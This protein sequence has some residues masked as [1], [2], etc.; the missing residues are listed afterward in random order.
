[1]ATH[2]RTFLKA[3]TISTG[4]AAALVGSI[5]SFIPKARA[6][7][8]V[9]T[10]YDKLPV[11][12]GNLERYPPF[13]KWNG[14]REMDGDDWKRGGIL[15]HDVKVNDYM[16]VP[17]VCNNC[18]A[19]CGLTA[20][21][22][23]E[24]LTVRKYMGN[25]LHTGS[26]GRNCAKG[27]AV[28]TQMYDPDRI[29]FPLKRAPGTKRGDGKW[30]RTTWDEAMATIGGK[31]REA[32][33]KGDEFTK[34]SIM[35]HVGRPNESGFTPRVW[36][37]LGQDF[38]N[39][40]T[41]ICSASGRF[42]SLLW[43]NDDR[44]SSD[45]SNARLI[46]LISS[47]AADAGHY[48]QQSARQIAEARKKGAKLVVLDPR[49]SNSAGMADLWIPCWPGSEAAIQL[50]IA[51]RLIKERRYNREFVRRWWNWQDFMASK[52]THQLLLEQGFITKLPAGEGFEAFEAFMEDMYGAYTLE[53][54]AEQARVP[55]SKLET[56]YE[57]FLYAGDRV[58][59]FHWRATAAGNRGGWMS[60]SRTG[61]FLI[62]LLGNYSG[63]GALGYHH[64]REIAVAGKGGK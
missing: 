19:V 55:L 52:D 6:G 59:S 41:N 13:E 8:S 31:M 4:A 27:Y 51:G 58:A 61:I 11:V 1:M 34:K 48:F 63:V 16:L 26:Q 42:G 64:G 43:A 40:H 12:N 20:W 9:A 39:S 3:A 32:L 45:W 7:E 2:R 35:H 46:F 25:P 47:H 56:L 37:S 14:W 57:Y 24:T 17:T 53:W 50:A 21:V 23:K 15:R 18:E 36:A 33:S 29:P 62:S 22:D 5:R 54:A 44:S 28:L 38:Q 30:V 10:K 49:L 60:S